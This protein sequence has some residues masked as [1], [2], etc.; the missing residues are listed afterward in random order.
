VSEQEVYVYNASSQVLSC[1]SCRPTGG[2][3]AGPSSIPGGTDYATSRAIYQSRVLSDVNQ[4]G[5]ARGARVFFNSVDAIVGQDSNRARDVYQWEED[6]VGSCRE[7]AGCVSLISSGTSGNESSFADA[8]ADGSNVFFLTYAQLV[9][10]DADGLVDVYDAREG[11]GFPAPGSSSAC[12]E[13]GCQGVPG[14]PPSYA[15]P[16]SGTFNGGDN[17][18]PAKPA[19]SKPLTAAQRLA[20]ALKACTRK[21]KR[22]RSSCRAQAK[23]RYAAG[24]KARANARKVPK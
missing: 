8:S 17:F 21:P 15:T 23:R 13:T 2:L 22:Q 11:G 1:A 6:G 18:P 9:P 19:P 16:P 24:R 7:A 10:Q 5:E 4:A 14:A 20:K 12:A 3:P